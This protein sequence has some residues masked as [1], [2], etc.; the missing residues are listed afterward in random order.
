[1]AVGRAEV[2]RL[3]AQL[4]LEEALGQVQLNLEITDRDVADVGMGEGVVADLVAFVENAFG[5]AGILFRLRAPIRKNVAFALTC[6]SFSTSRILGVHLGSGPS[7]KVMPLS[8]PACRRTCRPRT[9]R[10]VLK[11]FVAHQV[12]WD[13]RL[14]VRSPAA[15]RD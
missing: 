7:S 15:G 6:L 2:E 11:I 13:R 9:A 1:M 14:C 10:Q 4:A 3:N 5:D 8:F 12:G